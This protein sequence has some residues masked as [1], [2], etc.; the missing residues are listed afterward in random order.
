ML[1]KQVSQWD[2]RLIAGLLFFVGAAQWFLVIVLS[3]GLAP[4]YNGSI[5]YVS[6]LGVGLTAVLYN[7]SLILFGILIMLGGFFVYRAFKTRWFAVL[8][9]VT[10]IG[11]AGVGVFP[12]NIQPIHGIFQAIALIVGAI[13]AMWSYRYQRSPFSHIAFVL[14]L[15]SLGSC[16][17]FFP[18]MGLAMESTVRFLGLTKG[19]MERFVIYTLVI[20]L[21]GFGSYLI[22]S[23]PCETESN[24]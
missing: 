13:V 17:L 20:W 21:L 22:G 16:I 15:L 2:S 12:T 23:S 4:G 11:A 5:Y 6:D 19:S 7:S 3:E 18:Y 8:L 1:E 14:G 24:R 10:G 9:V